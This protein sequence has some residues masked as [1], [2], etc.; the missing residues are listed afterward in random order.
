MR[1]DDALSPVAA[2]FAEIRFNSPS[3]I[4]N[5]VLRFNAAVLKVNF[6]STHRH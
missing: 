2:V 4:K 5:N 6:F 1:K 3:N